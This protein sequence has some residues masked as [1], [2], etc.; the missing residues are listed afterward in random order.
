MTTA[1]H[2]RNRDGSWDTKPADGVGRDTDGVT[3]IRFEALDVSADTIT[4]GVRV[5]RCSSVTVH[6]GT[7]ST[8]FAT[9]DAVFE[10]QAGNP[11]GTW[12]D[13]GTTLTV[14]NATDSMDS[15]TIFDPPELLRLSLT[16][17]GTG[18]ATFYLEAHPTNY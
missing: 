1:L 16:S 15:T 5:G 9:S 18:V 12:N 14:A 10:I 7:V 17:A 2:Q 11:D 6:L 3:W 4:T 8:T 13:I